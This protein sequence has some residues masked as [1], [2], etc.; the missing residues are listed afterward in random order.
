MGGGETILF[1][2]EQKDDVI[3]H[4]CFEKVNSVILKRPNMNNGSF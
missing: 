1:Q 2:E 3:L 4:K